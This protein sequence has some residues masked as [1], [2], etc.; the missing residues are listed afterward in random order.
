MSYI[1]LVKEQ[2]FSTPKKVHVFVYRNVLCY[3]HFRTQIK[4]KEL[5]SFV[6]NR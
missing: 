2:V 4:L 5:F 3:I 6:A 1:Q